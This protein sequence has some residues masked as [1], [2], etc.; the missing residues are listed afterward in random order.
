MTSLCR[1]VDQ[2]EPFVAHNCDKYKNLTCWLISLSPHVRLVDK[3]SGH[4]FEFGS[5]VDDFYVILVEGSKMLYLAIK[6]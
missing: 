3:A 1:C 2:I 5:G 4:I 6:T